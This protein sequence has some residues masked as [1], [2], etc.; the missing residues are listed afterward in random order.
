MSVSMPQQPHT[1]SVRPTPAVPLGVWIRQLSL[2]SEQSSHCSEKD[3]LSTL[4]RG[5]SLSVSL[6]GVLSGRL[7]KGRWKH[8]TL[9]QA[10][11]NESIAR[12]PAKMSKWKP[13][14]MRQRRTHLNQTCRWP[15][16]TSSSCAEHFGPHPEPVQT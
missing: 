8:S 12:F 2:W 16:Q 6:S 10:F 1:N 4:F 14:P 5:L 9:A 15:S 3:V 11:E 13:A 7:D